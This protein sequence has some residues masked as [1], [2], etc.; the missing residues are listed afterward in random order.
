[1][2]NSTAPL[3]IEFDYM[4]RQG[5]PCTSIMGSPVQSSASDRNVSVAMEFV[6]HSGPGVQYPAKYSHPSITDTRDL[7]LLRGL[8]RTS[9]GQ[10][11]TISTVWTVSYGR[12]IRNSIRSLLEPSGKYSLALSQCL[13]S[14]CSSP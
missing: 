10:V 7:L 3:K 11:L 12:I 6:Q 5:V 9:E 4:T 14:A 1:M 13:A 8:E 2:Q